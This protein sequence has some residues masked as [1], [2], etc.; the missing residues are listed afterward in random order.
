MRNTS[1]TGEG[2]KV[3]YAGFSEC[4]PA[5]IEICGLSKWFQGAE[6]SLEALADVNLCIPGG[7]FI[8][9]V[10]Q[11]GCGKTTL[12]RLIAGLEAPTEGYVKVGGRLVEGTDWERGLI[13]QEPRLFPW[14]TVSHNVLLGLPGRGR[15]ALGHDAVMGLLRLVGLEDF[16]NAYPR[17]LSGGMAQR[18]ALARALAGSPE[19][20]LLDEPLGALD[21]ITRTRMQGELLSIW[22]RRTLTMIAVTHDLDEAILLSTHVVVL[23]PRPG[24]V[25]SIIPIALPYPR[26][27]TSAEFNVFR[28]VLMG[29]LLGEEDIGQRRG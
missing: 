4:A 14:A 10:G 28:Q 18:V 24:T 27:R 26:D 5:D 6:N 7:A 12:L 25:K 21:A 2:S 11:S 19:V 22:Q 9:I 1:Y 23:T 3:S 13:F 15:D 8:T 16:A 20:L 17:E 29:M